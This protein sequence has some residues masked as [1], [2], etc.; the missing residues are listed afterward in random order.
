MSISAVLRN[1]PSP[2]SEVELQVEVE[3]DEAVKL[4]KSVIRQIGSL[5]H[6]FLKFAQAR[7]LLKKRV[8]KLENLAALRP[9]VE[10]LELGGTVKAEEEGTFGSV[11]RWVGGKLE[12]EKMF[13]G[14][15][16]FSQFQRVPTKGAD[17]DDSGPEPKG[18]LSVP[19][20]ANAAIWPAVLRLRPLREF[21]EQE[22]R[23]NHFE[24]MLGIMPQAW[25]LDPAPIPHGGVI[26]GLEIEN[27]DAFGEEGEA[28]AGLFSVTDANAPVEFGG[29]VV[30]DEVLESLAGFPGKRSVL[31]AHAVGEDESEAS[32]WV[33]AIYRKAGQ[34]TQMVSALMCESVGEGN[35]LRVRRV[36][37]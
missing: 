26:P 19:E 36:E 13:L 32:A 5:G 27:W 22:L 25:L 23:R 37:G 12:L 20:E 17:G 11:F 14:E 30:R 35:S 24:G 3:K 33:V 16:E 28:E 4:G 31:T 6:V 21:W 15:A 18:P 10:N 2:Q 9:W 34:N 7:F 29:G 1:W 8:G